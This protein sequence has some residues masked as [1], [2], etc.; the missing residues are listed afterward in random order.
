MK[1]SE[2]RQLI[3]EEISKVVNEDLNVSNVRNGKKSFN[4]EMGLKL[5]DDI[6]RNDFGGF[7]DDLRHHENFKTWSSYHIGDL[8]LQYLIDNNKIK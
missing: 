5:N 7:I 8:I 3:R 1:K 4:S 6:F 2:L